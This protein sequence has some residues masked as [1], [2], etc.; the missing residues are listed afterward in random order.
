MMV[1]ILIALAA[2]AASALMFVSII[3]GALISLVLFYLAPLP[4]MVAALG[5]GAGSA[6]IGGLAA[7]AVIGAMIGL[8][9]MLAFIV[10]V[11][12]PAWWLGH[13]ALL[14]KPADGSPEAAQP[15]LEWYPP[16][17][18]LAWLAAFASLTT[19]TALLSLGY[20][21]T[22]ITDVLK[23][24]LT[25]MLGMRDSSG[26]D[27]ADAD[28]VITMLV[29]IAPAAATIV[30]M[31][32]LTLNLWLAGK[33]TRTSGRLPRPWPALAAVE[34][35][36][37]TLAALSLAIALCFTGGLLA[38]FS[39]IIT[40]AL[41]MGYAFVGFAVLHTLTQ[42]TAMRGLWLGSSYAVVMVFG[43]PLLVVA[44]IGIADAIFG[45]R[46]RKIQQLKPPT[47][48]S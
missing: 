35:P 12:L 31:V 41:V 38:L 26:I 11:A 13:L 25:R 40:A 6:L 18:L 36:P 21:A 4:L 30:A 44:L 42:A 1:Q 47:I 8:P 23:R 24:G 3:S 22:S 16:G 46:Q 33:I 27:A 48:S 14:A 43:W 37:M 5:W 29:A 32:T 9:Y 34:L 17:R 45:F 19:I 10:T 39:Q 28:K 20:D 2:G 7:S 15:I